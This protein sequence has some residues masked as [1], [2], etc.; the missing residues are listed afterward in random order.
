MCPGGQFI[1]GFWWHCSQIRGQNRQELTRAVFQRVSYDIV[2][3]EP[4][5]FNLLVYQSI[6]SSYTGQSE[7]NVAFLR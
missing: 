3:V 7:F 2:L 1:S 5:T 6:F 4:W